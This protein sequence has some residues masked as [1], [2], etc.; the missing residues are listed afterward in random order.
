MPYD[1]TKGKAMSCQSVN[2]CDGKIL[3]T[4][5]ELT[6]KQR[7]KVNRKWWVMKSGALL[8]TMFAL[9][10]CATEAPLQPAGLEQ[11]IATAR[12]RADHEEI[13]SV[14]EQQA[15][16]DKA[17]AERHRRLAQ[18]YRGRT[19]RNIPPNMARHCESLVRIYQQAA[20]ENLALAKEHRRVAAGTK[21]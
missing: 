7:M 3:K 20:E 2:P 11:R 4:F 17:A 16:A 14:Y 1:H 18:V 13:A 9:G 6:D 12:V 8:L 10:G 15:G 19:D 21:E 5:E